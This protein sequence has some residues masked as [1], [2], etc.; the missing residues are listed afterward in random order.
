MCIRDRAR[1]N[2]FD[3]IVASGEN[4]TILH[5]VENQ[6]VVKEG[7]LVLF[8]IGADYEHY[9]GDISRTF[10]V[11]RKFSPRQKILYNIV[12]KAQEEV[13]KAIK[14]GLH[15]S[16]LNEIAKNSLAEGCM[17]IGLI[18]EKEELSN[19][20]Y[21]GVSHYLGLDTHDIGN[22][23]RVLEPGMVITV[24]PGLYIEEESIGIRIEDDIL[25]TENGCDILSKDI[26]KTIEEIE[27]IMEYD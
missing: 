9:C 5:Y 18:K 27:R 26:P 15:F 23:N 21:H 20:Y 17:E 11:S 2:A 19:Y 13:I 25:V 4:A 6:E 3:P 10:P 8:D 12:L 22:R 7:D 1:D 14:P 16:K 24:E